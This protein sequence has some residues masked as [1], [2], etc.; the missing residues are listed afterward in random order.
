MITKEQLIPFKDNIEEAAIEF[1]KSART[2][3]R[4]LQK[5][6]LYNPQE[7]YRPGKITK[8]KAAE[9]RQLERYAN[10]TQTEIAKKYEISQA[11]VGRIINNLAY[12]SDFKFGGFT[13]VK[14]NPN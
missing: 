2:I 9:I 5:F 4:W 13:A 14:F 8:E 11:M 12:K 10:L 6:D 1:G 3:R 7:K